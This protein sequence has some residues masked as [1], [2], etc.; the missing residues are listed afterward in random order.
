MAVTLK[1]ILS[2]LR[3]GET[4]VLD[5][6]ENRYGEKIITY[7]LSF[8]RGQWLLTELNCLS[9][10][11]LGLGTCSCNSHPTWWTEKI[12]RKKALK[13]IRDYIAQEEEDET[14]RQ[15]EIEFLNRMIETA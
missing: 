3:S 2:D 9:S 8:E 12:N 14:K 11:D 1:E 6:T 4:L 15:K 7:E 10:I 5:T 13:L